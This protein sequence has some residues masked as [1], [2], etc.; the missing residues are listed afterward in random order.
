M[1]ELKFFK[2]FEIIRQGEKLSI[3]KSVSFEL[4]VSDIFFSSKF[5]FSASMKLL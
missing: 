4:F 5:K 1:Q 3:I 2:I